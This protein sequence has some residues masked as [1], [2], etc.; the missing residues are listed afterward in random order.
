MGKPNGFD[1]Q[2][3]CQRLRFFRESRGFSQKEMADALL[4][5]RSTYTSY[6]TGRALPSLGTV[7]AMTE[8]LQ[9][10]ADALLGIQPSS[11]LLKN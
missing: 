4:V 3:F 10:S 11:S 9:V 6:E 1:K 2:A 7:K 5:E 8:K